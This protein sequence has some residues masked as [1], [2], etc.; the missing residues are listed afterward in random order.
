MRVGLQQFDPTIGDIA[1][2]SMAIANAIAQADDLDILMFGELAVCGY[3]PRDLLLRDGFAH[4]CRRAVEQLAADVPDA[5]LVVVGTPWPVDGGVGNALVALRGGQVVDVAIKTLLP[6]YDVFDEDRYFTPGTTST[7]VDHAGH[8]IGLLVCE[9]CWQGGDVD[10]DPYPTDPVADV[11]ANGANVLA[12]ASA[13]PFIVGK[14]ERQCRRLADIARTHGVTVCAVNQ[15]GANDDLIFDGDAVVMSPSGEVIGL[16]EPFASTERLDVDLASPHPMAQPPH[17]ADARRVHALCTAIEGYVRKTGAEHVWVGLSGGIDSAVVTALAVSA[18][19]PAAVRC[20]TMPARYTGSDTLGDAQA[21]ASTL[22]I[23]LETIALEPL[24][25]AVR[26]ALG[27]GVIDG[28]LADQNVQ[29][30]LRGL[31]LMARSNAQG[32]L[33]LATGNK[34]ELAVGYA[35][36]YGDMNGALCPLGDVLKTDVVAM[37]RWINVNA[38]ALGLPSEPIPESIIERPPTAELRPDQLDEDSLPPYV[39]LDGIV[40]G[41]VEHEHDDATIAATLDVDEALV[42]TWRSAIDRA[43]FKR[44]QASVIPKV[45]ARAF[46]RGRPW[47]IVARPTGA[48]APEVV[49]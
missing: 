19:G 8:R 10:A 15:A 30:R 39:V 31:L 14:H 12:V 43:Q 9:D 41:V 44:N 45:S 5:L 2:N 6:A 25:S 1:G 36:L 28:D 47:P 16:R 33:V 48:P 20:I 17:D 27:E 3:P 35:T 40:R 29:A 34:S 11:V 4:A 21:M 46:G 49:D 37:A 24:H 22:G 26:T 13:S 7:C 38:N 23:D 18:M 42:G 32:G